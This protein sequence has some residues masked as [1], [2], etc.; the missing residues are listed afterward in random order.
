MGISDID[1][2]DLGEETEDFAKLLEESFKSQG[3]KQE[4]LQ[5]GKI[6]K[7][8]TEH[9]L[10]D[11]GRKQEAK[12]DI[13]EITDE[14][15]NQLFKVGDEIELLLGERGRVSYK[16]ALKRRKSTDFI[17]A[18]KDSAEPIDIEGLVTGKNKGGYIVEAGGVE[19]FMPISLAAFKPEAK[20]VGKPITARVIKMDEAN[21]SLVL[22]RRAFLNAQRKVRRESIKKLTDAGELLTATVKRIK[23]YG[24]F[25]EAEGVEGL[26]HYTEIS[27]KGPVNPALLYKEGDIV[28][29]KVIESDKEKNRVSFSIKATQPNPW[30]EIAEQLA[31]GDTIRVVVANMENYGAFVDLGNDA[32]GFLH[33]SE[34]GWDKNLKHPSEVLSIGEEIEVEVIGLEIESQRLRV[35]YKNLQEKPFETFAKK[36]KIG[37]VVKGTITALKEFGAFVRVDGVEGLLHNEDC[38]WNRADNAKKLFAIGDEV[39][40]AVIKLDKE[41]NRISFSRKA[42]DES[43]I[44][45]FAKKHAL[46][47]HVEGVV[48]DVKDFGVFVRIEDGVDALIRTEDVAPLNPEEIKIGDTIGASIAS[49][50]PAKGRIRLSVRR[51]EKQKERDTIKSFNTDERMTLGDA[52]KGSF[53][54]K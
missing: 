50:E 16:R 38:A 13:A 52:I 21:G 49:M 42:L 11:I 35:S 6:V 10:I 34:I 47:D 33:I 45:V 14:N 28:T 2:I 1:N 5:T 15:G 23:N 3:T 27:H 19:F 8:T 17:K 7:I 4:Q 22:S 25:V 31:V 44:E 32:E 40:V 53:K 46:G 51:H 12:L 48:R 20:P 30:Q 18:H 54:S 29:V 26:V 37:D 9:A 43:P 39:E 36:H 24:M 41:S